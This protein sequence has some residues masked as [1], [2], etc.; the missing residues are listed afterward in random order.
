MA[1]AANLLELALLPRS[2][3][4]EDTAGPDPNQEEEFGATARVEAPPR[5]VSKRTLEAKELSAAPGTFGDALRAIEILPGVASPPAGQSQPL[6]RGSNFQDSQVFFDG[7]P[8]PILYHLG[9]FRSF[10]NSRL[11]ERIDFYPGNFSTRYGRVSGGVI[12]VRARDPRADKWGGVV[13]VSLLDSSALVEGPIGPGASMAFA[14]RRSNVDLVFKSIAGS[15][16][17]DTVAAPVYY[18]YQYI[19]ALRP[20]DRDRVRVMMY[21]SRDRFELILAKPD[22]DD[23]L[24]RGDF[25][26]ST[27][28]HRIQTSWHRDLAAG[29]AQDIEIDAGTGTF[30]LVLGQGIQQKIS[31]FNLGGRAEWSF[32]LSSRLRASAGVD[33]KNEFFR[34]SYA[35]VQPIDSDG[36]VESPLGTQRRVSSPANLSAPQPAI[37]AELGVRP[38]DALLVTPG[39]RVDWFANFGRVAVDPR[40]S[41]RFEISPVLSLKGGV[42]S[43]SQPPEVWQVAE[44]FGNP[45]LRPFRAIQTSLGFDHR[46]SELV[47]ASLEG[48]YKQLG[49]RVVDT[50]GGVAP[51]YENDGVGRIYGGELLL[52]VAPQSPI[53]GLISYTVSRSERNDHS[54]GYRLFAYDQTHLLAASIGVPLGRGWE[55]GG[56]FRLSSGRPL[57][58]IVG[59]TY[60]AT[61]DLY[62]PRS[63]PLYAERSPVYHRLDVR[64]EKKWTFNAFS[65]ATYLDV[66]NAY[67]KQSI[68]GYL[69]NYDYTKSETVKGLPVLP[70]LGVRAEL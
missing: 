27:Q 66:Q 58:R 1:L 19:A 29:V 9:N 62:I 3:R 21:G 15:A 32:A 23:P 48:F 53:S 60:D 31:N 20:S 68:E 59:R 30:D 49:D 17:F 37:Y 5:E 35:G 55:L 39:V 4:A 2:A 8:V 65:L 16:N 42:G 12:E 43:F 24:L 22:Q 44:G 70:S 40:I 45:E 41:A 67:N 26:L 11:L 25:N 47:T 56:T 50:V 63:G 57:T 64:L 10:V 69:Y 36:A 18:D 51:R 54:Q 34:G 52:R 7:A 6:I 61:S 38:W 46:V 14:A 13:D 33:L 28:F